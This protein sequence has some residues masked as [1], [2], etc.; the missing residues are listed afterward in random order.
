M[1]LIAQLKS[2]YGQLMAK[3]MN[4]Y[5]Y[6]LYKCT[7]LVVSFGMFEG[8]AFVEVNTEIGS[9][10]LFRKTDESKAGIFFFFCRKIVKA[11]E[12]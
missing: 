4:V 6:Y 1:H 12:T 8:L 7:C 10:S 3:P 5:I 11:K 2:A 9:A